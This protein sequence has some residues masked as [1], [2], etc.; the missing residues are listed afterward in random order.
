KAEERRAS[1]AGRRWSVFCRS[2]RVTIRDAAWAGMRAAYLKASSN[3]TLPAHA[4]QIMYAARGAIQDT[5]GKPLDDQYFCQTLLP[6]YLREHPQA[7]AS[8]DVV[9]DARGHFREPHTGRSVPL[10]TLDV[11]HYLSEITRDPSTD[12]DISL[13]SGRH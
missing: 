9:F 12:L 7:T 8:W 1:A 6:D 11:R 3:G 13:P 4:R 5:T 2:D 10:G